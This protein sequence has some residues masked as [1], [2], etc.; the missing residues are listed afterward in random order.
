MIEDYYQ[1][2]SDLSFDKVK[3][4][5][6]FAMRG[7]LDG[8]F[9]AVDLVYN[10]FKNVATQILRKEQFL[11]IK[12]DENE[13]ENKPSTD[14]IFEPS[15]EFIGMFSDVAKV[16]MRSKTCC[17]FNRPTFSNGDRTL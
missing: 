15:V 8:E 3:D 12:T 5:A 14:Y 10:E 4:A 1:L 7:F 6:D 2:F 17:G 11:P 9:D 16:N 13:D